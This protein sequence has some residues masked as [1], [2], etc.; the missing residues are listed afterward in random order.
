MDLRVEALDKFPRVID[1]AHGSLQSQPW[2]RGH[3][4][5]RWDL[6][7]KVFR[8]SS[9]GQRYEV[10]VALKFMQRAPTRHPKCPDATSRHEW[11]FLMQHYGLPTRVLDWTESP[12]IAAYFAVREPRHDAVDGAV[13]AVDPFKMSEVLEGT[14]GLSDPRHPRAKKLIDKVFEGGVADDDYAI[15]VVTTEVDPRMMVQQA[16]LV[17][18][19]S[20]KALNQYEAMRPLLTRIV[21]DSS[22]KPALRSWLARM[23]I[24][25]R[26][27]FPDLEH[28]ASDLTA[29]R[30]AP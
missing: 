2:W 8:D 30:Y 28:L 20:P 21:I 10:N 26:T 9:R 22:V 12:L 5:A 6:V 16:A 18:H 24:R 13:W 17:V 14:A 29:D 19:G 1:E 3:T 15:G 25:E 11:L 7:P 4:D 27:V 23:G